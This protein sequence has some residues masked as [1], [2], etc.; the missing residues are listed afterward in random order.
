VSSTPLLVV[1]VEEDELVCPHCVFFP[2]AGG[3]YSALR[4]W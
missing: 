1:V 3:L 4:D 2:I